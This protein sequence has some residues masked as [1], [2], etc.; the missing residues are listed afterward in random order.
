MLSLAEAFEIPMAKVNPLKKV[1]NIIKHL[2]KIFSFG[3]KSCGAY[4]IY[5]WF[6]SSKFT[7]FQAKGFSKVYNFH[8]L[9]IHCIYK[10][11]WSVNILPQLCLALLENFT[12]FKLALSRSGIILAYI[13]EHLEKTQKLRNLQITISTSRWRIFSLSLSQYSLLYIVPL[14]LKRC[15]C[16]FAKWQLY[17]LNPKGT[18]YAIIHVVGMDIKHQLTFVHQLLLSETLNWDIS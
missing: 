16:H 7:S 1:G 15:T 12:W 13:W 8:K 5:F 3:E 11:I 6:C 4:W 10:P 17:L 9:L 2:K 18:T 14:E